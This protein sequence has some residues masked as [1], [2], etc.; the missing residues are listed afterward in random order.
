[1][2]F[3]S[4]GRT[5]LRSV[6]LLLQTAA[7]A[8]DPA[9]LTAPLVDNCIVTATNSSLVSALVSQA[10]KVTAQPLLVYITTNVSIGVSPKPP[11]GGI[12]INR[13]VVLVGLQTLPTSV[14]FQMVVNQLN[15]T[16][17][18]YSN[19]TFIGLVL[20]NLAGGDSISSAVA[21]PLSIAISNNV[22]A[23]NANRCVCCC[24]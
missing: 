1:M 6:G 12:A 18:N 8:A 4:D 21:A 10:A 14:D 20:E 15:A 23:V 3:W 7:E 13:P 9:Q 11:S 19:V 16:G 24:I 5:T 17:S 22:W 2:P